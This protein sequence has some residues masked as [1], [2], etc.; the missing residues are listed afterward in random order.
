[1]LEI[2]IGPGPVVRPPED[3]G[4]APALTIIGLVVFLEIRLYILQ[5]PVIQHKTGENNRSLMFIWAM[6]NGGVKFQR[7]IMC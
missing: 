3:I 7:Y 4:P 2:L 6:A 5:G 1:M